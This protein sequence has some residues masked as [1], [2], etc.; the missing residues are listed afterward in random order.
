MHY[1]DEVAHRRA[2]RQ[3]ALQML[4]QLDAQGFDVNEH[5]P[6][7]IHQSLIKSSTDPENRYD[8]PWKVN[9]L[10]DSKDHQQAFERALGAW[11]IAKEADDFATRL[12]P[13]WPTARQPAIDRAIVRLCWYE[14][15]TH[16][17]PPKAAVNEA[18][19]LGKTF[20]TEKSANF[21]NGILDKMLKHILNTQTETPTPEPIGP[22]PPL[23]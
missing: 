19:E 9:T 5:D 12:A 3:L 8:G 2:V 17:A 6:E 7:T 10:P 18:I 20:S 23:T 15:T 1:L 13:D 4:Y 16:F 11:K 22:P 21:L 14:M